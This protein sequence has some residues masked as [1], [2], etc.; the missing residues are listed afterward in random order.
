MKEIR[1]SINLYL[2]RQ[3]ENMVAVS[4]NSRSRDYHSDL[5]SFSP[6]QLQLFSK[7]SLMEIIEAMYIS[8]VDD[9]TEDKEPA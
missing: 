8:N 9:V 3:I 2:D 4:P 7:E 6:E 1:L 5:E